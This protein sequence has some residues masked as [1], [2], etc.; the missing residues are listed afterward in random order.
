MSGLVWSG[1]AWLLSTLTNSL[2]YEDAYQVGPMSVP[3]NFE[4]NFLF[5]LNRLTKGQNL[6]NPTD[7]GLCCN[8]VKAN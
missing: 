3:S 5:A 8:N 2:F 4:L 7:I 6:N 1:L